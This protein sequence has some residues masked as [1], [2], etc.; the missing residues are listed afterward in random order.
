MLLTIFSA[1]S[2]HREVLM[3]VLLTDYDVT[4]CNKYNVIKDVDGRLVITM[5][6]IIAIYEIEHINVDFL[7]IYFDFRSAFH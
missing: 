5:T 4:T 1:E 2:I 3:V 7:F 6:L